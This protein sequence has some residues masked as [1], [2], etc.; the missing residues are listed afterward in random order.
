M[1]PF[2]LCVDVSIKQYK[3]EKHYMN[4]VENRAHTFQ[5]NNLNSYSR[6]MAVVFSSSFRVSFL[7]D[8]YQYF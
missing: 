2:K 6:K 1:C 3:R 8:C 7:V 4:C 5:L